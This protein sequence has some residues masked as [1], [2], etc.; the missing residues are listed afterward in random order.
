MRQNNT[1]GWGEGRGYGYKIHIFYSHNN[2]RTFGGSIW[3][4]TMSLQHPQI[5]PPEVKCKN[6]MKSSIG[7]TRAG[8]VK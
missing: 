5:V 3:R 1:V 7:M 6:M 8:G 4:P 2:I